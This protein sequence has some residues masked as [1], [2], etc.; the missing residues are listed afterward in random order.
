M[1][2]ADSLQAMVAQGGVPGKVGEVF[3]G[4]S[5]EGYQFMGHQTDYSVGGAIETGQ[6]LSHDIQNSIL[7]P[8]TWS[9]GDEG[10][11]GGYMRGLARG[12]TLVGERGPEIFRPS[13]SGQVI[14]N[15]RSRHI[16]SNSLEGSNM[17]R[18]GMG[19]NMIVEKLIAGESQFNRSKIG[20]DTFAG[21]A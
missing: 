21:V 20:V 1:G 8:M 19:G 13:T 10:A 4:T 2:L 3:Y 6:G 14:N 9:W 11:S 7:N 17:P 5:G 15:S 18:G 16:L 12:G